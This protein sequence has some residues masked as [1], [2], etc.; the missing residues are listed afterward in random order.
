[1]D[2][3]LLYRNMGNP[4]Y[5]IKEVEF[6]YREVKEFRMSN[7]RERRSSSKDDGEGSNDL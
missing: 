6:S 1:M 7:L 5:G 2:K 4:A 3:L